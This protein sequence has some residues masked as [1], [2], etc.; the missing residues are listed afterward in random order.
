MKPRPRTASL[1][2]KAYRYIHDLVLGGRLKP[3]TRLTVRPIAET[4]GLSPTPVN[5]A[6]GMLAEEG[7]VD[8]R[9]HRGYFVPVMSVR[10]MTEIYEVRR[11]LDLVAIRR[12][13]EAENHREIA[14][15]LAA[16][17]EEQRKKI[18]EEDTDGFIALDIVFH[19]KIWEL[20][21]NHCLHN[22]GRYLIDRMRMGNAVSLHRTGRLPESLSEHLRIVAAVAAG[23][24]ERGEQE[25]C[26]HLHATERAY[27]EAIKQVSGRSTV[28]LS[29]STRHS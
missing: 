6:L 2:D 21:G 1:T 12:V 13:C 24:P 29:P 20:C 19:E 16:E 5:T 10:D 14:A 7:I 26:R 11:G 28:P 15:E 3:G 22:T 4:L 18:A 8:A 9:M 25:V 27:A 17:C 23:D